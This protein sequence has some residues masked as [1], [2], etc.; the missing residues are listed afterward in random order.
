MEY[1]ITRFNTPHIHA[2][3]KMLAKVITSPHDQHA[4]LLIQGN[5]GSGKSSVGLEIGYLTAKEVDRIKNKGFD[6]PNGGWRKYF[7]LDH[8]GVMFLDKIL[9][10]IEKIEQYGIYGL[11]DIGVGY[12]AREWRSEKNQR[13]NKIFETM[14]TDNTVVYVTIPDSSLLDKV[15][16]ELI[17]RYI[18]TNLDDN[19]YDQGFNIVKHFNVERL[20]RESKILH[21]SPLIEQALEYNQYVRYMVDRPPDELFT[22]YRK[23]RREYGK[24][25]REMEAQAAREAKEARMSD[26]KRDGEKI[27]KKQVMA[28]KVYRVKK[29]VENEEGTITELAADEGITRQEYYYY[30]PQ[31][32]QLEAACM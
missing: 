2:I 17:N 30:L 32:K 20:M 7:S 27:T 11:D 19:Y 15:P 18:E 1:T 24:R 6:V 22:P 25:L 13:M 9:D 5:T 29:R 16:R 10:L 4:T 12:S 3:S 8:V 21:I 31:A 23:M 26:T 28:A 14:R